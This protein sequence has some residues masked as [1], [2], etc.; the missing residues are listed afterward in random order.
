[1][2]GFEEYSN[3]SEFLHKWT[4]QGSF[5]LTTTGPRTGL[6]CL[7]APNTTWIS[8]SFPDDSHATMIVG[9]AFYTMNQ[10]VDQTLFQFRG[11]NT[12]TT[13]VSIVKDN[14][15]KIRVTRG[16]RTGTTLG[17]TTEKY[18]RLNVW[19][20]IEAK[21]VLHDSAGSVHVR[22]NGFEVL[23]ITDVDTKNGGTSTELDS[24]YIGQ[25]E[26][27]TNADDQRIDDI[28]ICN[29]AGEIHNDFL[30]PCKVYTLK[31]DG[32]GTYSEFTG[33]DSDSTDNYLLVDDLPL[34]T[35]SDY[36]EASTD[37]SIDTYTFEDVPTD[38]EV[39]GIELRA[40]ALKTGTGAKSFAFVTRINDTDYTSDDIPLGESVALYSQL[41]TEN[42]DTSATWEAAEINAAE[43]GVKARP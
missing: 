19:E 30:G 7:S 24:I 40:A 35:G 20:Y 33:S 34:T 37:D 3:A 18:I 5:G 41:M 11:D 23:A 10:E 36:V 31:P 29:G 32:N 21:V 43:F 17:V 16:G 25:I 4:A 8:Q 39:I 22:V 15:G 1:M 42:P 38:G 9:A 14:Q 27:S 28:Y 26:R 13:H 2:E 12:A 6:R